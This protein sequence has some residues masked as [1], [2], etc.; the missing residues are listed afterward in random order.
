MHYV[1]FYWSPEGRPITTIKAKTAKDA[2]RQFRRQ[3]K[4]YAR[5]MGEVYT[6][7]N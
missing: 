5:F 4:Q 2:F 1:T 3:Y 7:V 6:E